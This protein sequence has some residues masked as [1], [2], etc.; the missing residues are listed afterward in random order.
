MLCNLNL[1]LAQLI[2]NSLIEI[3]RLRGNA[4]K[5]L[6]I[7]NFYFDVIVISIAFTGIFSNF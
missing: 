2:Y 7:L 6:K 3:V 1:C 5:W 4:D